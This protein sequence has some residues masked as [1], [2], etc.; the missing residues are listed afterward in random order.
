MA[1]IV[2]S[3]EWVAEWAGEIR[4]SDEYRAAAKRWEWPLLFVL[5][6]DAV[7]PEDRHVFLDLWR[8]E[9]REARLATAADVERAGF[10][11]SADL[12]TW[13]DVLQRRLDPIAGVARG[14]LR[15]EKGSMMTLAMH[16]AAAKALVVTAGRVPT[17]FPDGRAER[18]SAAHVSRPAVGVL[19]NARTRHD[20]FVTTSTEGLRNDILPMRLFRKAKRLGVWNPDDIDF[21]RD[22]DDWDRLDAEQKDL[23]L[24]LTAMFLAGEESVTLDLLPLI[25]TIA[26]EG[27]LEE[28]MFLTTFLWEEAKHVDFFHNGF[29]RNVAPDAGD[30]SR[31]HTPSYRRIFYEELPQAMGA[32]LTDASPAA[33]VRA[34]ATYNMVVEGV[35]AETGYDAYFTA[36]QENDLLPGLREGIGHLKRDESRHIAYGVFLL[37]RLIAEDGALWTVV[38]S[39]MNELFPVALEMINE[40]FAAYDVVP[41]GLRLEHFTDIAVTNFSRRMQRIERARSQTL[42][43]IYDVAAADAALEP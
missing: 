43:E 10:V 31:Y 29:L 2:F 27:R 8:G 1:S 32:L 38:E 22:R 12:S 33:Q 24:R 14:R 4:A 36:L 5:R 3:C 23:L 17:V 26:A 35:L 37:S 11:L 16:T 21:S 25:M 9:C 30:L 20:T 40:I 13:K 42:D 15:L 18:T 7:V 19:P 34:S 41:F 28:E 39:R 6:A